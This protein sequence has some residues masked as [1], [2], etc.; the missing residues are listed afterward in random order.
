[1]N[2]N[3]VDVFS[4][5]LKDTNQLL[6]SDINLFEEKINE[7]APQAMEECYLLVKAVQCG[8]YD[9]YL[10]TPF[11]SKKTMIDL[12]CSKAEVNENEAVFTIGVIEQVINKQAMQMS[13]LNIEEMKKSALD[14]DNIAQIRSIALS[15]YQGEGVLQDYEEAFHLFLHLLKLG[16]TSILGYLGY[17]YEYGLG[18]E[19]NMMKAIEYYE[20]GCVIQ[21]QQCLYYLGLCYLNGKGYLKNEKM[22]LS[23]LKQCSFVDAYM[24]LGFYYKEKG[25]EGEAFYYFKKAAYFY[26]RE[27]L[28]EVG[29][30]Y[31]DGIGTLRDIEQAKK[32]LS[33]ASYFHHKE[34]IYR[35]GFMMINGLGYEKDI[36]LGLDYIR[37]AAHMKCRDACFMLGKFYEYGMYVDKDIYQATHYYSMVKEEEKDES[38]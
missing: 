34:A 19:E 14:N 5:Y 30:C 6:I 33:Y 8:V 17:M 7:M 37:K 16:D 4:K 10:L 21:D 9:M 29:Y 20:R 11:V 36:T 12:F 15:Y 28:Y 22:A 31:L 25:I 27:A 32:Y 35:I 23:C 3:I 38:L 24:V 1:M 2:L 26:D 18:V 13:I